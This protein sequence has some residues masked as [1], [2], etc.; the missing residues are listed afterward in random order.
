M[1]SLR[2]S[3]ELYDSFSAPLMNIIS[4]VNL[5]MSVMEQMQSVMNENIDTSS[6]QGMREQV[7]QATMAIQEL[8]A[9]MQNI[10]APDA[11]AGLPSSAPD[12]NADPSSPASDTTAPPSPVPEPV[13]VP[14]I[15]QADNLDVFTN[16]GIERF[17][18]EVQSTNTMLGSLHRTQAS[19]AATASQSNIFPPGMA[20][21]MSAMQTRLQAIQS[22]IQV[23]QN[24]PVNMGTDRANRELE[25]L[26]AQL[27][28]ALSAQ[29]MMNQAVENMDVQAANEAYLRMSQIVGNTE[30]HIRDNTDEEG[31]FN[32]EIREGVDAASDLKGMIAGA[33]GAFAGMAGLKKAKEWIDDCTAAFN[34]QLNAE[35]QLISVLANMLDA[36]YVAQFEV[37]A[38]TAEAVNAIHFIQDE[39]SMDY[40]VQLEV[41]ADTAKAVNAIHSIQDEVSPVIVPV[42]AEARALTAAY[43]QITQKASEI[44]G[45]GIYGDEIMI[46]GAAEFATYFSDTEAIE[47]MM[48]TLSN[49]A[50]GMSGGGALDAS[51]MVGYATDL[52]KIMTGSYGAMTKK[53][54]EFTDAQKAIVEGEA[55]RAQIV[56]VLGEEYLTMSEDMQAAAAISQVIDEA[57]GGLYETMSNTPEGKIIQ[58]NNTWGDMMEVVGKQLYPY[59]ILFVDAITENWPTIQTMLD[60]TTVGLEY[61]LGVMSWLMEGAINFAQAVMDNWGWICPIIYGIVGA[62]AVY[63]AYLAITQGLGLASAAASGVMAVWE[64][65]HA[66]AIWATTG[67]TWAEVT[68]QNGLNAAMY[69]CPIV[70]I[71]V[72]VIALVAAFYAAVAAV[73]RFAGTS[74]SATGII[75]G[76]FAVLGAHIANTFIVPTWNGFA[77]LAN[78]FGNV[79][80]NPVAAIKVLFYDMCLTVIGYIQNLASAIETLINKIPGVTV[81]ITSGLDNFYSG[82]EQAQQAVKDE[83]GWVE[84]VQ[85][86]DFIDYTSAWDAGYSFGEGIDES[87]SNFDPSSLFGITD[88]PSADDYANA[89]TAGGLSDVGGGVDDISGNT[90]AMADAMDITEEEL[91]YMRDLAER[92][93]VNR[94]TTA[95]IKIEQTN[96][97]NIKNDMDLDGIVSGITEA[98]HES[99]LMAA[100]GVH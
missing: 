25:Q 33:V 47:T 73:N 18:M 37:E 42:R 35:T 13:E 93:V 53:G 68:A 87:I 43:D 45:K 70:W 29:E 63:G 14:V 60:A 39:A 8:N 10:T 72:L 57:W 34:T 24:N 61:M 21:D 31:R 67:A 97:N 26:R 3:I 98:M 40:A 66:A 86:M 100:E 41:E 6:F 46:A 95:E 81:D 59:V 55:T 84:Y 77:S 94:F 16:S 71:I 17:E 30:R 65:I 9:A 38:D 22:R 19:I 44:Q 69:A 89:L 88:I 64:G 4:A 85:K 78:F 96:H 2:S 80:N 54:F 23:I 12:T 49:Y 76:L 32:N 51:S 27:S 5:S 56:S 62:L 36:D 20:A 48:D 52:G 15:W 83:S 90:G 50:M 92:E 7:D 82:L 58:M 11:G 28:Q 91:K 99:V 1:G 75:A 79:F 74:I